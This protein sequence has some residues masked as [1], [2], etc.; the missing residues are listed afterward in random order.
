MTNPL[1]SDAEFPL[2]EEILP[3]HVPGAI[4]AVLVDGE[5][6]LAVV[7]AMTDMSDATFEGTLM[8]LQSV[9]CILLH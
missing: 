1:L 7:E 9:G 5:A 3:E 6:A 4:E 2:F 8:P